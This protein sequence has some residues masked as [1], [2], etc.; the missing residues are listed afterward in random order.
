MRKI[1]GNKHNKSVLHKKTEKK[2]EIKRKRNV[3]VET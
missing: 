1:P 2:Q 3:Y